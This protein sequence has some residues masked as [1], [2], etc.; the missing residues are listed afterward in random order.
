MDHISLTLLVTIY[1]TIFTHGMKRFGRFEATVNFN[2]LS[3]DE[4]DVSRERCAIR[5]AFG[6]FANNTTLTYL[7][8]LAILCFN[9]GE[10]ISCV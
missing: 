5:Y 10:T 3:L 7:T 2:G 1:L 4:G 9:A 8:Y 6:V